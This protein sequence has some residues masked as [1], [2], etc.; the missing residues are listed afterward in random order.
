MLRSLAVLAVACACAAPA[1]ANTPSH[2]YSANLQLRGGVLGLGRIGG[3]L[4]TASFGNLNS[5]NV[6][7]PEGA[8]TIPDHLT[9]HGGGNAVTCLPFAKY[10]ARCCSSC[11]VYGTYTIPFREPVFADP[12]SWGMA[13]LSLRRSAS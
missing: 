1:G 12:S 2:T 7:A 8:V 10:L 6:V 9:L 5:P 11:F 13:R 3:F 4:R